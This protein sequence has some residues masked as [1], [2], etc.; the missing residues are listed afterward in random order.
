[1]GRDPGEVTCKGRTETQFQR[2]SYVTGRTSGRPSDFGLKC[3]VKKK[4]QVPHT[5]KTHRSSITKTRRLKLSARNVC[6]YCETH[7][8]HINT[9]RRICCMLNRCLCP[10]GSALKVLHFC[11]PW[12][13]D[14]EGPNS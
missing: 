2:A 1:V 8:N 4:I 9:V 7:T 5:Q 3:E 12:H 11:F 10:V 13:I 14:M 6:L